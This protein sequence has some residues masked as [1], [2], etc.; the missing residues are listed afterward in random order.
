MVGLMWR[1]KTQLLVQM[2][3]ILVIIMR[4]QVTKVKALMIM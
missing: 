3:V 2:K 1:H 4:M